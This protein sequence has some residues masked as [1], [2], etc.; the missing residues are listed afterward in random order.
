MGLSY[1]RNWL[2]MLRLLCTASASWWDTP[3]SAARLV[4]PRLHGFAQTGVAVM[5]FRLLAK[6]GKQNYFSDRGTV[7]YNF[8]VENAFFVLLTVYAATQ[9]TV[10]LR[11]VTPL[12]VELV[13][14]VLLYVTVRH[15]FLNNYS[16]QRLRFLTRVVPSS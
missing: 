7:S 14:S 6:D 4:A 3:A 12:A 5:S 13:G 10:T 8:V 15:N 9:T 2:D 16:H 11:C 1:L